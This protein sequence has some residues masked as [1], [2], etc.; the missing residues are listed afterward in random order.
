MASRRERRERR[1]RRGGER[2]GRAGNREEGASVL[3]ICNCSVPRSLVR[4]ASAA[5]GTMVAHTAGIVYISPSQST[6]TNSLSGQAW[7]HPS[8]PTKTPT[9]FINIF[10]K[11]LRLGEDRKV[12]FPG[13]AAMELSFES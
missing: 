3:I 13:E 6:K 12:H 2:G 1:E 9:R 7:Y 5:S 10:T 8:Q 4:E 11:L